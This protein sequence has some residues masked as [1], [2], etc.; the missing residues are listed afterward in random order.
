MKNEPKLMKEIH[1]IRAR[2]YLSEI[3]L[4][5]HDIVKKRD[6][7][8]QEVDKIIKEYGLNVLSVNNLSRHAI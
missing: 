8:V 6:D 5:K 1:D 4:S 3:G 2:N 7:E